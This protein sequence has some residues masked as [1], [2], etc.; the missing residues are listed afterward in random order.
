MK[1]AG[2]PGRL[3]VGWGFVIVGEAVTSDESWVTRGKCRSENA[4]RPGNAELG[5]RNGEAT[6]HAKNA[7][8]SKKENRRASIF[9]K[10]E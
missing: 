4:E 2:S 5:M 7:K 8:R 3:I 10:L 9:A 6:S 1:N